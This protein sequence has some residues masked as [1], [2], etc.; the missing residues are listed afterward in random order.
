MRCGECGTEVSYVRKALWC[1][2]CERYLRLGE[3]RALEKARKEAS[4]PDA[5][6]PKPFNRAE[7]MTRTR[8]K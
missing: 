8:F 3:Q 1:W 5:K 2:K 7:F 4:E 6:P